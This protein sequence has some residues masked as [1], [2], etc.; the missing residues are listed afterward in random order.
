VGADVVDGEDVGVG[1]SGGGPGLPLEPLA[2]G[3]ELGRQHL[4]RDVAAEPL[5][6]SGA[7]IS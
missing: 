7:T 1:E 4:D 3:G 5:A 2:V 6:P